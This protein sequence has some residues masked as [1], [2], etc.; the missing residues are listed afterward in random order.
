M[1]TSRRHMAKIGL[2]LEKWEK[3]VIKLSNL[4]EKIRKFD[5]RFK[6]LY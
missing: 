1:S 6:V 4:W 2:K 3:I 5:K